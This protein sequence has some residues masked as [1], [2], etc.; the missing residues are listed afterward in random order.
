[1]KRFI[2]CAVAF[3]LLLGTVLC[4]ASCS[5]PQ[6]GNEST[7]PVNGTTDQ[8][9]SGLPFGKEN[10]DKEFKI[11][12]YTAAMYR[13]FYFDDVT[14]AGDL[15]EQALFDRR[16]YVEDYLGVEVIG[17]AESN[18]E[19]SIAT[20]LSRDN[21]AGMDN[22]QLALTHGY[23]GL[24]T[25]L[26]QGSVIDLYDLEYVS[27]NEDYYNINA[28]NNLSIGGKVYFGSSDFNIADVCAVFFNKTMYDAQDFDETPYDLVRDGKWTLENFKILCSNVQE[29]LGDPVWDKND[30]YGLGVRADWEFIPLV[31]ACNVEWL[32]GGS[33]KS[34]NMGPNNERYQAV[35]DWCEEVADAGWSYMYNYGDDDNKVTIADGRFLFTMEAVKNAYKYLASEVKFGVLPYPKFDEAQTEYYSLDASGFFCVPTTAQN[36]EMVGKVIECLSYYSADT[37][38]LAYYERLLGTRVAEAPDD[39]EMLANYVFG[40]ITSNAAFN[41]SAK[42]NQPL[43]ILVYTIP[44]ML[45]AKLNGTTIDTIATNWASYKVAAQ[46]VIDSTIN[47]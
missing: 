4:C 38:H 18:K 9:T 29:N 14:E 22:Y 26:S 6:E 28:I 11:L 47:Q 27:F 1:M 24:G 37:I 8:T 43:G 32:I 2:V 13:D 19:D 7:G 15:I 39:A 23:I 17:V 33:N 30:K 34:L 3:L 41:Y 42:A 21:L 45:R 46:G 20:V 10:Y 16:M 44:K 35:Y 5:N 25:M 36:Q 40:N 31:D 12:Y